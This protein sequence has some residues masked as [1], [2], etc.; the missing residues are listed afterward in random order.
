MRHIHNVLGHAEQ[1]SR[2]VEEEFCCGGGIGISQVPLEEEGTS[3][4]NSLSY[5]A[6]STSDESPGL[7]GT[8]DG[9]YSSVNKGSV[10]SALSEFRSS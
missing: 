10:L 6:L 9:S 2:V 7:Q 5:E 4:K 8:P 3:D 1:E